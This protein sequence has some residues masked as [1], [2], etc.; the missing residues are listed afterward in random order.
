MTNKIK[1]IEDEIYGK[2]HKLKLQ[3]EEDAHMIE[4]VIKE[5]APIQ[6]GFCYEVYDEDHILTYSYGYAFL[7]E[8]EVVLIYGSFTYDPYAR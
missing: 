6:K 4:D 1:A 7:Y 8:G 3:S 5:Y 2:I